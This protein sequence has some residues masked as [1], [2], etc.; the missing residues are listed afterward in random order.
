MIIN[1]NMSSIFSNSL[2]KI[3]GWEVDKNIEKLSSV[4]RINRAGD[5][6]SGLAVS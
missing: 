6:A 2:L 4:L 5:Y 3:D 1:H